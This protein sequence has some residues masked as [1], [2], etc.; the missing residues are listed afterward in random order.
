MTAPSTKWKEKLLPDEARLHASHVKAFEEIRDIKNARWGKGRQLHRQQQLAL[1]GEFEVLAKLPAHA[2]HGLFA[3]PARYEAW[4]R[5]SN[6]GMDKQK[7]TRPDIRGFA[8]K[9]RGLEALDKPNALG[10]GTASSQDFLLIQKAA[11]G[12]KGSEE[13]VGFVLNAARGPG[14]LLKHVFGSLGIVGGFRRMKKMAATLK[15]PFT[16]YAT[17]KFYTA[18]PFACGPYAARARLLPA[19]TEVNP[20]A[21]ASWS[22]DVSNRLAKGTLR[23]EFQLQ[24]FVDEDRTP[25]E[26]QTNEWPEDVAPFVTVGVLTL[27]T[28]DPQSAEGSALA[29]SIDEAAF[30]PWNALAD[31][32][33][34]GEAMRARKVVY[35]Q[36]Q[37]WRK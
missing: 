20:A 5:L 15:M 7:D 8:L 18:M 26:D 35:Y 14:A 24:F 22:D 25:I 31:H 16:G 30:D 9:V 10:S 29:A 28:Q 2:R 12:F 11:F 4:V 17:E 32:R 33:P 27:P 21:N 37:I 23:F 1:K 3:Q 13:F 19:S 34:L 6:G 36:S